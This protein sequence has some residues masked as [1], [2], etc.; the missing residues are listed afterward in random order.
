MNYRTNENFETTDPDQAVVRKM[1]RG[2]NGRFVPRP[3]PGPLHD[4][5]PVSHPE[6]RNWSSPGA[7]PSLQSAAELN[8]IREV[9]L[10]HLM[11]FQH[12]ASCP[13]C[14][15]VAVLR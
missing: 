10:N 13:V 8:K 15:P 4:M 5:Q 14:Q 9:H 12:M 6:R 1:A 7:A 2:A 11:D 3:A